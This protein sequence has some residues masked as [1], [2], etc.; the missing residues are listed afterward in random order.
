MKFVKCS[1]FNLATIWGSGPLAF[2]VGPPFTSTPE[3]PYH[4]EDTMRP[5]LREVKT[6]SGYVDVMA[7]LKNQQ[8]PEPCMIL[9][10]GDCDLEAF[11]RE[12]AH[13]P[14][15]DCSYSPWV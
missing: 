9:H 1:N 6:D 4:R 7:V 2:S 13:V 3:P 11:C 12:P 5:T 15:A 14:D 10:R 8:D